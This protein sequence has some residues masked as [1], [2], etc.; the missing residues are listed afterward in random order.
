M[1]TCL[2]FLIPLCIYRGDFNVREG[3]FKVCF[4]FIQF[5][6]HVC[7][8]ISNSVDTIRFGSKRPDN[9]IT[10][11]L[12]TFHH[13]SARSRIS[14]QVNC[15]RTPNPPWFLMYISIDLQNWRLRSTQRKPIYCHVLSDYRRVLDYQLDLLG[16]NQLHNSVTVYTLYNSQQL[17]LFSSSEDFG[18]NS[19]TTAATSSYGVPCHHSLTP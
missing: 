7:F 17:T 12:R 9:W 19:A 1:L 6:F 13:V 11:T 16:H 15:L 18:S 4:S 2:Y 3:C 5:Y 14:L 10:S 8:F